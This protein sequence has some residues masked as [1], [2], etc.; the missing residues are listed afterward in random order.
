M[1]NHIVLYPKFCKM[2]QTSMCVFTMDT[3]NAKV[4]FQVVNSKLSKEEIL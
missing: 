2:L 1:N 4:Y 3:A